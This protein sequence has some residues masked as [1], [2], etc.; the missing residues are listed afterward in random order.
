MTKAQ[1]R[2]KARALAKRS[3]WIVVAATIGKDL[4]SRWAGR[5]GPAPSTDGSTHRSLALGESLA[6]IDSVLADYIDYGE[7]AGEKLSGKR[8]LELGP[9]DNHGVALGFVAYGAE[10]VVSVDRFASIRDNPQQRRIYQALLDRL[11]SDTRTTVSRAIELG[12]EIRFDEQRLRPIEG[13]AIEDASQIL[14]PGGFDLIVSRAVLEHLEDSDA[15]FAAMDRLL[16]PGGT[17]LHKVDFRDH[18]MFTG[19]GLHPLTFLTI[20]ERPY[21]WM[22]HHSG[23]PNRRLADWYRSKLRQLGYETR[24]LVT[25]IVG[26]AE[27][28]VPHTDGYRLDRKRDRRTLELIAAIRPALRAKFKRLSDEDLATSGVFL[29]AHKPH[30]TEQPS[31]PVVTSIPTV[32]RRAGPT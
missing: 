2:S 5:T 12:D 15:A 18:G 13:L 3:K 31:E 32:P 21:G 4:Q 11:D 28:I 23:R 7:L 30:G 22:T 17:M 26:V 14:E 24:L 6:Y 19:G 8:I 1:A 9:G 27:E 20:P 29:I 25:H 10:R 16:A